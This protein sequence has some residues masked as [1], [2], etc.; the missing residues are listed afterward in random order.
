MY[1]I[2]GIVFLIL[3]IEI[4]GLYM[5]FT[6]KAYIKK[7]IPIT[8][9]NLL[10]IIPA[11]VLIYLL[12]LT[13]RLY[14]GVRVDFFVCFDL[15]HTT[16]DAF[17]FQIDEYV[18]EICK[19]GLFFA[20]FVIA[21]VLAVATVIL[22]VL[23]FFGLWIHNY[24]VGKRR[25]RKG[26]DLVLGDSD[27]SLLYLKANPDSVMLAPNI[28][29]KRY[30]ELLKSGVAVQRFGLDSKA[31]KKKARKKDFDIIVF[32]DSGY[33]YTKII[34]EFSKLKKNGCRAELHFEA[35]LEETKFIRQ[36][37]IN[38]A[39]KQ[40]ESHIRCFNK[41]ELIARKF[42]VDHPITKYI[43]RDF[44]NAN[45]SIKDNKKI[46][47]VFI[48]FGKVNYQLFRMFAMQFQFAGEENGRLKSKPVDYY[49]Y[50]N[51]E[52]ALS[53]E[54][55]SRIE[56]EFDEI[57]SDCDFPKPENICEMHV[58]NADI[59]SCE[60]KKEFKSLVG[61]D[62][63]TYFIISLDDDLKDA[64]YARTV[65]RLFDDGD[66][67]KIFVRAKNRS[68][69]TLNVKTDSVVYFGD[70]KSLYTHESIVDDVLSETAQRLNLLYEMT[71]NESQDEED[72]EPIDAERHTQNS[73]VADKQST[74]EN[75]KTAEQ[76][77]C[78][79]LDEFLKD[80][81][82]RKYMLDL[83]SNLKMI[84]QS[85]NLYRALNIPFKLA[86]LGFDMV[87]SGGEVTEKEFFNRYAKVD[88]AKECRKKYDDYSV[89]FGTEPCNVLAYI[90]HLRWNALYILYD[91]KQMKKSEMKIIEKIKKGKTVKEVEHRNKDELRHG[92]LTTYYGLDDLIKFKFERLYG[93]SEAENVKNTDSRLLALSEIYKYDYIDL[94]DLYSSVL[95]L[96]YSVTDRLKNNEAVKAD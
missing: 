13:A 71:K 82:N 36:Q 72:K 49:I 45:F 22:G 47:I 30:V 42:V 33:P 81:E 86:M 27:S 35:T 89:Y 2:L 63:Y 93:R 31:L 17:G 87:K 61:K 43:P 37:F 9:K 91:F 92:C 74:D 62:S 50:D 25:F 26:C 94:D 70:D 5:F 84:D 67:Y 1:K 7:K 16:L 14:C 75:E 58:E 29:G 60:V 66:N 79:K 15:V 55:R 80:P 32:R 20:D 77:R 40:I 3:E 85:S 18:V 24:S 8:K 19:D 46:N 59:N 83:W 4:I 64:A 68:G 11:F 21:Y 69:E 44:Y 39:G 53:N 88:S 73:T 41:Y 90:E 78:D 57:F 51:N 65:R 6:I 38:K 54:F 52:S 76:K 12:E 96:G 10:Y 34:D 28:T 95:T 56:F 48:G 23:G